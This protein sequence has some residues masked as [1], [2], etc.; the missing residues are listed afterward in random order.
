MTEHL[1]HMKIPLACCTQLMSKYSLN[2]RTLR[3]QFNAKLEKSRQQT[4]KTTAHNTFNL[5]ESPLYINNRW[6][7]Y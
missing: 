4:C 5:K 3:S 7:F 1:K 2:S 6:A